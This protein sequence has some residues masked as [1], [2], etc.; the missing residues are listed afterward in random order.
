MAFKALQ[1]SSVL[2]MFLMAFSGFDRVASAD[3]YSPLHITPTIKI[4]TI[5]SLNNSAPTHGYDNPYSQPNIKFHGGPTMKNNIKVY[6]ILYGTF[7]GTGPALLQNFLS[8]LGTSRWWKI[9]Q[10]YNTGSIGFGGMYRIPATKKMLTT[11]DVEK[12]IQTTALKS[13]G[14]T[15]DLYI[16]LSDKTVD[17]SDI[18]AGNG[19]CKV[20]CGWHGYM[21]YNNKNI[22]YAWIGSP[23]RCPSVVGYSSCSA[24][25]PNGKDSPNASVEMDGLMSIFSHEL[26]EAAS[27]PNLNAWYNINGWENADMCVWDFGKYFVGTPSNPKGVWNEIVGTKKY[28]L[29]ENWDLKKQTCVN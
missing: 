9:N 24:L 29:Q 28:L 8:N 17:Q 19:F 11:P 7:A 27:D 13:G 14:S 15:N 3:S 23:V 5:P 20:Y 6:V 16:L 22:K 12:I 4:G 21:T 25:N 18:G 26:A 2:C 1:V 10:E